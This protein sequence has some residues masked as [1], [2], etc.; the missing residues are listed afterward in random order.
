MH[1]HWNEA[2]EDVAR[3][4]RRNADDGPGVGLE[5]MPEALDAARDANGPARIVVVPDR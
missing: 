3:P 4:P 1:D 2:F 5:E